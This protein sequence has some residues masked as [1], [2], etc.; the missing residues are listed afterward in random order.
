MKTI[1]KVRERDY[2]GVVE[3]MWRIVTEETG[4]RR[5]RVM[6]EKDEGGVF[7]GIRQL[8]RGVGSTS[9]LRVV[10]L[11]TVR[12]GCYSSLDCV[13]IGSGQR[14]TRRIR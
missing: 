9:S 6:T 5:K 7:S 13:R 10:P 11:T 14:R 2:I 1:V 3:G 12:N 8:Y 4:V